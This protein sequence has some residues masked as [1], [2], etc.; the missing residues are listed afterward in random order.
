MTAIPEYGKLYDGDLQ[1]RLNLDFFQQNGGRKPS[2]YIQKSHSTS[3][4]Y[5]HFLMQ[6]YALSNTFFSHDC[7][8]PIKIEI[9]CLIWNQ[10]VIHITEHVSVQMLKG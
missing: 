6:K 8:V 3:I 9:G 4:A 7:L 5:G 1:L 10:L 2:M